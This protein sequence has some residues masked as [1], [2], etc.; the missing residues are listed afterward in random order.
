MGEKL[1]TFETNDKIVNCSS[2]FS[3]NDNKYPYAYND[4]NIY[5][6]IHKKYIPFQEHGTSTEK[7]SI[8]I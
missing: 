3:F 1:V 7:T 8:T 2:D 5:F 6:M 4:E